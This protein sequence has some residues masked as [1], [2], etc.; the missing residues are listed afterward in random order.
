MRKVVIFAKKKS[1]WSVVPDL[2]LLNI[3][4]QEMENDGWELVSATANTG[5][6]GAIYSFTLVI[7]LTEKQH[8]TKT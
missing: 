8:I 5:L 7:E 2:D 4:I 6:F 1:S 3:Q